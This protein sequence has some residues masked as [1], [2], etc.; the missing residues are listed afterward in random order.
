MGASNLL[1]GSNFKLRFRGLRIQSR[2]SF[3]IENFS[4]YRIT[5]FF[6]QY[7]TE[8]EHIPI[9]GSFGGYKDPEGSDTDRSQTYFR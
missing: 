8:V 1:N 5:S 2:K 4:C 6:L 7:N 3:D 9:F